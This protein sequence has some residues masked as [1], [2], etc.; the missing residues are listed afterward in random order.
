[1]NN[2]EERIARVTFNAKNGNLYDYIIPSYMKDLKI[3]DYAVVQTER[4]YQIVQIVDIVDDS[5]IASKYIID[6]VDLG[7]YEEYIENKKARENL[8]LKMEKRLEESNRLLLY[9]QLAESDPVMK[10]L[11]EELGKLS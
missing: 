4:S 9:R 7:Q 5:D 3:D 10:S 11:L 8:M 2:M 1:M 6:T